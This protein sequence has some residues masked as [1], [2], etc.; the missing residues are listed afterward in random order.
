MTMTPRE[1]F[2]EF[3][4]TVDAALESMPIAALPARTV[5]TYLLSSVFYYL[6]IVRED[7]WSAGDTLTY[8][9][10]YLLPWLHR[11]SPGSPD[12][13]PAIRMA[14]FKRADPTGADA[15]NLISYAHFCEVAPE[16]HRGRLDVEPIENGFRLVHPSA[17][18]AKWE[19]IDIIVSELAINHVLHTGK[20]MPDREI[21]RL[22][23]SAPNLDDRL[24]TRALKRREVFYRNNVQEALLVDSSAMIGI[25]GFDQAR[26]ATIQAAMLA[27]AD[28]FMQLAKA[29]WA[30]STGYDKTPSEE[31]LEWA[32]PCWTYEGFLEKIAALSGASRL[33]VERF[34]SRFSF[35][36]T[37]PAN[38]MR[39]GDGFTPPFFRLE[40]AIM[41]SPDLIGRFLHPRN[42]LAAMVQTDSKL[43]N[44]LISHSLEPTLVDAV[45]EAFDKFRT[46]LV[47]KNVDF[48]GGEFDLVIADAEGRH[49]LICEVKAPLPPHGSRLTQRLADRI[50]NEGLAQLARAR[51]MEPLA[52]AAILERALGLNVTH[53][54]ITYLI[55]TRACFGAVEVWDADA[56]TVPATLSLIRLALVRILEKG[57]NPA[58]DLPGKIRD[59]L[60]ELIENSKFEW[61]HGAMPICGQMVE[62]P[63]LNFNRQAVDSWMRQANAA[64][65]RLGKSAKVPRGGR[66]GTSGR[67]S[68]KKK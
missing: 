19:A 65:I 43:F 29:L 15:K 52:R 6:H 53:A 13:G 5:L 20:R 31:T 56:E 33:D 36:F 46:T 11:R 21:L 18:T 61:S 8:R 64:R 7:F 14:N 42:A 24:L 48:D 39:G 45:E 17:Q 22:A 3:E 44:E 34:I 66:R 27:I 40:D 26:F 63:Q 25:F 49:V 60:T 67:K 51:T 30:I 47:R 12:G 62:T 16:V 57:G 9:I 32:V 59:V 1:R 38:R 54:K 55:V 37:L 23:E 35:E 10:S 50:R 41:F 68:E 58:R 28:V 2:F 4:H